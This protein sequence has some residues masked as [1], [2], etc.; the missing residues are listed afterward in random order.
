MLP[1][2]QRSSS[3]KVPFYTNT[4][5]QHRKSLNESL[6][7]KTHNENSQI[8]NLSLLVNTSDYES[9]ESPS[10]SDTEKIN[11]ND[12]KKQDLIIKKLEE[13]HEEN[14][15]INRNKC[16][17]NLPWN[18]DDCDKLEILNYIHDWSFPIFTFAEQSDNFVLSKVCQLHVLLS[19]SVPSI[20]LLLSLYELYSRW[21]IK[22]SKK[23]DYLKHLI[24]QLMHL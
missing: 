16:I 21:L 9:G 19:S 23:Q 10:G 3:L 4:K 17:N 20:S 11:T 24:Y 13:I 18:T 12:N 6:L 14:K 22:Y 8:D 7:L 15:L 1:I 2:R 5:N